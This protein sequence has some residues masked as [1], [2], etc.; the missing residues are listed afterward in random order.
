MRRPVMYLAGLFLA[1]G[2]SLA[3]AGPA[4]AAP[5]HDHHNRHCHHDGWGWGGH[6]FGD[7]YTYVNHTDINSHNSWKLIDL[8][9]LNLGGFGGDKVEPQ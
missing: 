6:D 5:S 2:A 9:L 8:G 7:D 1:T 4:N 3:L